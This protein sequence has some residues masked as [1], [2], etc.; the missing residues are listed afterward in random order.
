MSKIYADDKNNVNGYKNIINC[1][2]YDGK[3]YMV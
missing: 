3:L 1:I 2:L